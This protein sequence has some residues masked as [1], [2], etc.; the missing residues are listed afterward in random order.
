MHNWIQ[1]DT[2][3]MF[4]NAPPIFYI[5]CDRHTDR[6]A[7]V[8]SMFAGLGLTAARVAAD[9]DTAMAVESSTPIF[10]AAEIGIAV[11]HLRALRE[12][13]ESPAADTALICED[14]ISFETAQLWGATWATV[15]EKLSNFGAPEGESFDVAQLS[16]TFVPGRPAEVGL[17]WRAGEYSAGAYLV[18]RAHAESLLARH[19]NPHTR[20][21]RRITQPEALLFDGARC[22]SAPLFTVT[23]ESCRRAPEPED[24]TQGR[25]LAF[26]AYSRQATLRVWG[27]SSL[28]TLAG[29]LADYPA[30]PAEFE[31][32]IS[33]QSQ[34]DLAVDHIFYINL[35]HRTDRRAEIET[36]MRVHGLVAERFSAIRDD[37]GAVGCS[38]SHIAVWRLAKE[39]GY[40]RTLVIEDDF[41]LSVDI[42]RFR[43]D[44]AAACEFGFD[45]C[46]VAYNGEQIEALGPAQRGQLCRL[47]K[48]RTTGGYIV[49]SAYIDRLIDVCEPSVELLA[50]TRK[51]HKY[52][53]DMVIAPLQAADNWICTAQHLGTQRPSFSDIESRF[54]A[55]GV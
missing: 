25:S 48:A 8:E 28:S 18:R 42:A 24:Q 7:R 36:E 3:I 16:I 21:W 34:N 51:K 12:F 10:A 6:R 52:A 44:I 19:W 13:V 30:A 1:G 23:E 50:K 41:M 9:V 53:I 38:R 37:F 31:S 40:R 11:A 20:R 26:R 54:V 15:V 5:N 4:A 49:D 39:R 17:H 35:D 22:L 32:K 45:V 29:L 33:D 46:M 55:Y 14:E 47:L 43:T 27:A 2:T